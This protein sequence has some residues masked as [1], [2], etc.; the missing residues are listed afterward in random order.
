MSCWVQNFSIKMS[1]FLK[2]IFDIIGDV[3]NPIGKMVFP[4]N[5]VFLTKSGSDIVSNL[6]IASRLD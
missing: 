6:V 3:L 2:T 4:A 5:S 1:N